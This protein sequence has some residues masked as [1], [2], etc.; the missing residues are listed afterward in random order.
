MQPEPELIPHSS[1]PNLLGVYQLSSANQLIGYLVP[2]SHL[3]PDFFQTL[4]YSF[5]FAQN[6]T[7]SVPHLFSSV[8]QTLF[9]PQ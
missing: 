7:D 9:Q 4:C 8:H 6:L 2:Q 5:H 3:Q 1:F